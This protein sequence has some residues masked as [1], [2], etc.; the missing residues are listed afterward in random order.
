MFQ[1]RWSNRKRSARIQH[2][3][4]FPI[5]RFGSESSYAIPLHH[6]ADP[7]TTKSS[8]SASVRL[9]KQALELN[10]ATLMDYSFRL[11]LTY[12]TGVSCCI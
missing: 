9:D 2:F 11:V 6:K 7:D 8:Q 4:S 5:S 1:V 12:P 10:N 3:P